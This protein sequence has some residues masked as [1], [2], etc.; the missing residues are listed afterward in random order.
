MK[1]IYLKQIVKYFDKITKI[2]KTLMNYK[3]CL[4]KK[5]CFS[6]WKIKLVMS[7]NN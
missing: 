3:T 6:I 7:N 4:I 5:S 1:K 2:A